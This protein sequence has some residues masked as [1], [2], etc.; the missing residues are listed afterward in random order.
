MKRT[1]LQNSPENHTQSGF[2]VNIAIAGTG[3]SGIYCA[4]QLIEEFNKTGQNNYQITLFDPLET[5]ATILPTGNGRCNLAYAEND[6]KKLAAFYPRGEKFLYS[7][8]SRYSTRE[9]LE[10]FEKIGIKTYEQP[11]KRIFPISNSAKNVRMQMISELK[12]SKNVKIIKKSVKNKE[13]LDKFNIIVLATGSKDRY[14]LAEQ[15]GHTV[16]PFKPALCGLK[17]KEITPQFPT[18]VSFNTDEGGIIFTHQGIS[19]PAIFKI[20]SINANKSFPYTVKIPIINPEEL[21][22]AIHKWPKKSFLNV[23]SSFVPRALAV[24]ILERHNINGVKQACHASKADIEKLK[25]LEFTA[26]SPDGKGEIVHAGGVLL[27]EVDKNCKSKIAPNLWI[28]GESLNIDGFCGGFN[29][30]NCWSG[31]AIAAQDIVKSALNQA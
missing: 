23:V 15:F 19:G 4:L 27:D 18:G 25:I 29:L 2:K 5:L 10:Y 22:G 3:P 14:T 8:F 6:F 26:L 16:I 12:K 9:T 7:I 13:D 11:D 1:D 20:T 31:G 21:F 24:Y 30:Q 28:I 17:V